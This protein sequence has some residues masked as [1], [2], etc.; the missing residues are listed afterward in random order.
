VSA[1]PENER[2]VTSLDEGSQFPTEWGKDCPPGEATPADGIVF[3]RVLN[4]PVA[5]SDFLSWVESERHGIGAHRL[6]EA[7]GLSAFRSI[8]D[9]RAYAE[10]YPDSGNMVAKA[11]LNSDD[12]KLKPTPRYGNSHVT[13]WPFDGIDRSCKFTVSMS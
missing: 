10:R 8:N 4:N 13:W 11:E 5:T 2:K 1:E 9:A 12:G 3:R 7:R 6:C